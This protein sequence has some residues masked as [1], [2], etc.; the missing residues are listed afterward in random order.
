MIRVPS[1][2][3]RRK[4][5]VRPNLIPIL[6]AVFIFIFFLLMSASFLKIFEINSVIPTIS[7]RPPPPN[8][9]P[10]LSLVLRINNRAISVYTGIPERLITSFNSVGPGLYDLEGLH[11]YLLKL[12]KTHPS[13][14]TVILEPLVDLK[15]ENIVKIMDAIR[16]FRNTDESMYYKDKNGLDVKETKLFDNIIFG[17]I[18]S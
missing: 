5:E 7:D 1:R 11:N 15:Y 13:E 12:K 14:R 8:Q 17:N 3:L 16:M 10:P 6:D 4:N 9:K 2:K 18:Q